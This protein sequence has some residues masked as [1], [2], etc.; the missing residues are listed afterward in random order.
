MT[1]AI[2]REST[3]Y[4]FD[5]PQQVRLRVEVWVGSIDVTATET[6]TTTVELTGDQELIDAAKVEQRGDEIAVLVPRGKAGLFRKGGHID[7]RIVVPAGSRARLTSGS[8]DMV[9]RGPLGDVKAES[10]SGEVE[11]EAGADVEVKT[12]SGDINVG[13]VSGRAN[14]KSGSAD[15]E[16]GGIDRDADI[17][18]GSGDVV[19]RSVG[20]QLKLKA[21]SGDVSLQQGGD[22]V[23]AMVGSG[24]VT[25]GRID[26]GR[27]KVKT[28]SGDIM[29]GVAT[30]ISTYLDVMTVTGDVRS[31]LEGSE[32]P[33]QGSPTAEVTIQS[34]S[35][36]VVLQRA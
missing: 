14:V 15:V 5:T 27:V 33:E 18:T 24:D 12:G 29:V 26:R 9:T 3:V 25:I 10:G 4:E 31:D 6:T 34:G 13:A 7:A 23:D 1:M 30:G 28:G 16:I 22:G 35:G 2:N 17:L 11:I 32:P 36:D 8:A 20:G 21:G 19:V